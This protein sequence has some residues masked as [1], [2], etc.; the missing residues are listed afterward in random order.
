MRG[1]HNP[2]LRQYKKPVVSVFS[3]QACNGQVEEFEFSAP[4]RCCVDSALGAADI[5]YDEVIDGCRTAC[6][7]K[8]LGPGSVC[9]LRNGAQSVKLIF[10]KNARHVCTYFTEAGSFDLGVL[11][12]DLACDFSDG[13]CRIAIRYTLDSGGAAFSEN[14]IV[15]DVKEDDGDV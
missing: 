9:V 11:V 13:R 15:V 2:M 3:R 6:T 12:H 4:C 10:E 14:E 5:S 7:I 1:L 8:V